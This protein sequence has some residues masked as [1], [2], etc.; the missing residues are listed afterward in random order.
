MT[1]DLSSVNRHYEGNRSKNQVVR[2]DLHQAKSLQEYEYQEMMR[3]YQRELEE[4]LEND[5]RIAAQIQE[6]E[7]RAR[8]VS[9]SGLQR[10]ESIVERDRLI[11]ERLQAKEKMKLL[12]YKLFKE[13]RQVER[14]A[15]GSGLSNGTHSP[16][17]GDN[18][19]NHSND[20]GANG[21]TCNGTHGINGRNRF[22]SGQHGDIVDIS[23]LTEFCMKPPDDLTEEEKRIFLEEQDA[24]L[25]RF[26]QKQEASRNQGKKSV[27]ESH[28]AEI[29]RILQ[30]QEKAKARKLREKARQRAI[31]RQQ[32]QEQRDQATSGPS[33]IGN[34]VQSDGRHP[35]HHV[36]SNGTHAQPHGQNGQTQYHQKQVGQQTSSAHSPSSSSASS[37][38][39]HSS[40]S[41][42]FQHSS[43]SNLFQHSS[44]SNL[45]QHSSVSNLF[46]H[47]SVSN[48]FQH[49]SGPNQFQHPPV[50]GYHSHSHHQQHQSPGHS[51]VPSHQAQ[52][53]CQG[54]NSN[55]NPLRNSNGSGSHSH[56]V[57]NNNN[58]CHGD[59]PSS[60][61][62]TSRDSSHNFD[63]F[64][65]LVHSEE[66]E[67]DDENPIVDRYYP[68]GD[69]LKRMNHSSQ[70]CPD[71]RESSNG[72]PS[73]GRSTGK[74]ASS[75]VSKS[76][77]FHN[78]AMDLDPT[79]NRGATSNS[80]SNGQSSSG[81]PAGQSSEVDVNGL[82]FAHLCRVSPTI[83]DVQRNG[84][85]PVSNLTRTRNRSGEEVVS[86]NPAILP[87]P[88]H[89]RQD[90]KKNKKMADGCK[91]Q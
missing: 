79:Y 51:S 88:G 17:V 36:Q 81:H 47:S 60:H 19:S 29:A 26:L 66:E 38:A 13:K 6:Q 56:C 82:H 33:A 31:Q 70:R 5:A 42:L 57:N 20:S 11:A 62:H 16:A 14:V 24:E 21:A 23:D 2:S 58:Y 22:R 55:N 40:G 90:K 37:A 63:T 64:D 45:F 80:P 25:A 3:R 9:K 74:V 89:R 41:N 72:R 86:I 61:C 30:E 43:G 53:S 1:N 49:S 91:Q 83:D 32:L 12:K 46:Q 50:S 4:Q 67:Y 68:V 75:D 77:N 59:T 48:Q 28:D 52:S 54:I 10:E 27:I 15:S 87:V 85:Q 78:I 18:H 39:S 7:M 44:V 69:D 35:D 34:R 73:S 76:S 71:G 65:T 84:V 8:D